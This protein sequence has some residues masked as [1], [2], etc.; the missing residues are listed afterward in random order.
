MY[1]EFT[2]L[3]RNT[4]VF[5]HEKINKPLFHAYLTNVYVGCVDISLG[6]IVISC[7]LNTIVII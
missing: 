5:K 3:E 7:Q 1:K 2:I 6:I 4:G